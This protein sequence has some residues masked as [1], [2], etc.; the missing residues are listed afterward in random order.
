MEGNTQVNISTR[1]PFVTVYFRGP[2]TVSYEVLKESSRR[3][4]KEEKK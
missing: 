1:E 4:D 3:G 2:D